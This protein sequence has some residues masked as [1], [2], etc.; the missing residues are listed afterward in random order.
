M[1]QKCGVLYTDDIGSITACVIGMYVR[2]RS[3]RVCL[4]IGWLAGW[5]VL[6]FLCW[7]CANLGP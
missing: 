6:S 5:R 2:V 3:A 7:V 4:G 1:K